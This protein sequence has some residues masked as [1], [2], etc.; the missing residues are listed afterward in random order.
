MDLVNLNHGHMSRTILELAPPLQTSAKLQQA[1]VL[2]LTSD[3]RA[4][5]L[6]AAESGFECG[7][8]R[9]QSRDLTT[10]PVRPMVG[11]FRELS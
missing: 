11:K 7:A 6:H 8:L 10:S 4:T 3:L 9:L 5:G 1:N 2:P